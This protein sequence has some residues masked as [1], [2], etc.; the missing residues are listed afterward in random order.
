MSTASKI[1]WTKTTWNPVTGCDRIS[2]GCDRC[3][4]LTLA[5]RLKAMGSQKYQADGDPGPAGRA[6]PSPFTRMRSGSRCG[7]A[8][9]GWCS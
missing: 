5:K 2:S 8:S 9:P 7:G 4:A 1:E 6:S 3:Y